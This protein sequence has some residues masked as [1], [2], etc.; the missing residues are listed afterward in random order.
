MDYDKLFAVFYDIKVKNAEVF[1][2]GIEKCRL[3]N[4]LLGKNLENLDNFAQKIKILLDKEK[5]GQFVDLLQL[6]FPT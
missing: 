6:P 2:K 5:N 1:A 4:R 3:L